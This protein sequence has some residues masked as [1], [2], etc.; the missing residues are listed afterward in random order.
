[1]SFESETDGLSRFLDQLGRFKVLTPA[2]EQV[3]AKRVEEGDADAKR[4]MIEH[5]LR[6]VVSIAKNYR[7]YG[8]PLEDL[9]NEGTIGLNR[10]VEKFDRTKGFKFSTYATW[11]IKQACQRAIANKGATIRLPAHIVDR[12]LRALRYMARN[13]NATIEDVAERL[14]CSVEQLEDVL[15]IKPVVSLD[16]EVTEDRD[17]STLLELQEDETA[18]DPFDEVEEDAELIASVQEAIGLLPDLE[19]QV[20]ELRFGFDG[21][22]RSLP[23]VGRELDLKTDKVSDTQAKALVRLEYL[24]ECDIFTG[25]S[26]MGAAPDASERRTA[27]DPSSDTGLDDQDAAPHRILLV[28]QA[29]SRYGDPDKPFDGR[30]GKRLAELAG[31]DQLESV[32]DMMNLINEWP[33]KNGKGDDFPFEEASQAAA[34]ADVGG[35]DLVIL[36]GRS[37]ARAFGHGKRPYLE[38]FFDDDREVEMMV[39]PHPSGVSRWWNDEGNVRRARHALTEVLAE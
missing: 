35:Y 17:A 34:N 11:W 18:E 21:K 31:V 5:N 23:E 12:R 10:A 36:A 22:P 27:R 25:K 6:L 13:P 16:Q 38:I 14:K 39:F 33:G 37:V 32:M 2:E 15:E 9:I 24:L 19:R 4:L 20:L 8:M 1:M 7:N 3:M 28:G 26:A 30:S 29:P